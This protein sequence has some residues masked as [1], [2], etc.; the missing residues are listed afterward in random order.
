MQTDRT[1]MNK[2]FQNEKNTAMVQVI[3]SFAFG[4]LLSPW[5]S[6]LFFLIVYIIIYEILYYI[7]T[8]G[9]PIFYSV[10]VRTGVIYASILGFIVGRTLSGCNVLY[11]GVPDMPNL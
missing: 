4:I 1:I 6:G 3:T 11:E 10:F 9:D 7:F 8:K 5:G 2:F